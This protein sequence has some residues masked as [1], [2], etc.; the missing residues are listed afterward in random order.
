[1]RRAK[2]GVAPQSGQR[3]SNLESTGQL[4]WAGGESRSR[5]IT[6]FEEPPMTSSNRLSFIQNGTFVNEMAS[7]NEA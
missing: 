4:D 6:L 5:S 2:M 3:A 1:M 7:S